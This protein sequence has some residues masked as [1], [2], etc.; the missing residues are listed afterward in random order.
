MGQTSSTGAT[1]SREI[2]VINDFQE[3]KLKLEGELS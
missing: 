2:N 1:I 3:Q